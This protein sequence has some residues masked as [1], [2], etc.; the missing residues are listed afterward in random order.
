M[1]YIINRKTAEK[2]SKSAKPPKKLAK[3]GNRIQ[4]RQETDSTVTSGVYSANYT[5]TYFI[6]V[7]VNVMDFSE[8][9]VS[10]SMFLNQSL[11]FC[12]SLEAGLCGLIFRKAA[13]NGAQLT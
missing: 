1:G 10:I 3:T 13:G 9:F 12:R 8:H 2:T 4:N 5:N 11:Y 7:L 6:K